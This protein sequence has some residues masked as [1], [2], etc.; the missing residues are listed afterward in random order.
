M[1]LRLGTRASQLATTQSGMVAR[2]IEAAAAARGVDVEVELVHITTEGDVNRASL[3]GLSQTGVFVNALRDALLADECDL[4]VHSLKDIPVVQPEDIELAAVPPREDVRDALC[5]RGEAL[6][7]LPAGA[8]VGTGSPRR[9][10][11]VLALRPDL[12]VEGIR[13]NVDTRLGKLHDGFDAV[14]LAAAG[15]ARLGRSDDVTEFFAEDSMV[16]APGQGA[17]SIEIKPDADPAWADIVRSLDD[18]AT[19]AAVTAERT[20]L[21]VLEAGCAAPVAAYATVD[22]PRL[23]LHARVVNTAGTLVLNETASGPVAQ[24]AALG[25]STGHTLLGRGAAR[26]MGGTK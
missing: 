22:G 3:V 11:Q 7:D 18:P 6:A 10:A 14:V 26:L 4:L 5:T 23:T 20:V 12:T 9:A 21:Q 8:R 15:L 17:L 24:A 19:R 16:P 13:G 25:R 2:D 1:K